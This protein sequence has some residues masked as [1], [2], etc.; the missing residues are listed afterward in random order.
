MKSARTTK[1]HTARTR[2]RSARPKQALANVA[3]ELATLRVSVLGLAAGCDIVARN[4]G[5]LNP[6]AVANILWSIAGVRPAPVAT[7]DSKESE[8]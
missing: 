4:G 6:G 5:T 2:T 7:P 3:A 8:P 1:G